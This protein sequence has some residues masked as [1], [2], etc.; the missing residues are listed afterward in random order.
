MTLL[1]TCLLVLVA[2]L[3]SGEAAAQRT[4]QSMYTDIAGASCRK[5]VDEKITGASTSTC[6]GIGGFRLQVLTDDERN[7]INVIAPDG[8]VFALAYWDVVTH[9]FSTLERRAEWRVRAEQGKP[10][11]IAI[12]IR[13]NSVDQSEPDQ[14]KRVPLLAVAKI[15]GDMA[16][17][18]EKIDSRNPNANKIARMSADRDDWTCLQSKSKPR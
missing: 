18:I 12:I 10:V 5:A 17:V 2:I 8:K 4:I 9:G 11:P 14:P 7:S 6:P 1:P 15:G 16:C 3:C 13:V